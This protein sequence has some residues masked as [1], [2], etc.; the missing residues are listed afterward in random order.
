MINYKKLLVLWFHQCLVVRSKV[1][2]CLQSYQSIEPRE[3]MFRSLCALFLTYTGRNIFFSYWK[4]IKNVACDIEETLSLRM[5][6]LLRVNCPILG[7]LPG[8]TPALFSLSS[9]QYMQQQYADDIMPF[10]GDF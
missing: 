9:H 5:V 3:L 2:N 4:Y 1:I 10:F 7:P 6:S 8:P